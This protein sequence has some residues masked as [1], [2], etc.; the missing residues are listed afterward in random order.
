MPFRPVRVAGGVRL[1]LPPVFTD[2]VMDGGGS[3]RDGLSILRARRPAEALTASVSDSAGCSTL[4]SDIVFGV[5]RPERLAER[6]DF[7]G[8]RAIFLGL[9]NA[10]AGFQTLADRR[11]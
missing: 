5:A 1:W 3:C 6:R 7:F 11:Q 10:A 2:W 9:R 4:L 8:C